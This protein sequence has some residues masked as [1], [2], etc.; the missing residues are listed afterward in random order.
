MVRKSD[1]AGI[2]FFF[3]VIA[4]VLYV[5]FGTDLFIG[6]NTIAVYPKFCEGEVVGENCRTG[7]KR[8][9]RVTYTVS[10][11]HQFVLSQLDDSPPVRLNN[12][13]VVDKNNWQC[14]SVVGNMFGFVNGTYN[15]P[16]AEKYKSGRNTYKMD[17]LLTSK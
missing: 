12:W 3:F 9:N 16:L 11:E 14:T 7:W 10:A 4:A 1:D 5:S 15:D 13:S 8:G 6:S 2:L 17:W